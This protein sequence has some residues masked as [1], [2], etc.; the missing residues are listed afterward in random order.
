LKVLQQK[1]ITGHAG[2]MEREEIKMLNEIG[3]AGMKRDSR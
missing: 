1:G 2:S 3:A